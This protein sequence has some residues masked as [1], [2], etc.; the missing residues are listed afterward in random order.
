MPGLEIPLAYSWGS[1]VPLAGDSFD[2]WISNLAKADSLNG[3]L[4]WR[5]YYYQDEAG[6]HEGGIS[7][8]ERRIHKLADLYG[9]N[10]DRMLVEIVPREITADVRS[11]PIPAVEVDVMRESDVL[12]YYG[13]TAEICFPIAD[14]L[15]LPVVSLKTLTAW[16]KTR[17]ETMNR[18]LHLTGTA[19]G[20]GIAESS[21][22]AI[23]RAQYIKEFWLARGVADASIQLSAGQRNSPYPLRNRC[24]MIYFELNPQ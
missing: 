2:I 17:G 6:S 18:K 21:D 5:G 13:D 12:H 11:K 8:V 24:V 20:T 10:K 23:E 14:S 22:M 9:F 15:T 1:D 4:I 3:I 7:L 19:D 16:G